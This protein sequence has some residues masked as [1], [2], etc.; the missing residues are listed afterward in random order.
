MWGS[1][2][3]AYYWEQRAGGPPWERKGA[4]VDQNPASYA[5]NFKTPMLITHGERDYRVPI[6]QGFEIYKLLQRKQ[7]PSKLIVFP[8]ANHWVL[9]GEDA[10]FHM[11]EVL[12]WLQKYL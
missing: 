6:S 9:K 7:V 11:A 2:D 1:T 5:G 12:A 10:R 4:W 3:G 8:D